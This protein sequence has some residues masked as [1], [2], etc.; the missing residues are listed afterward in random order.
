MEK[1]EFT[2]AQEYRYNRAGP[3]RWIAS[4]VMRYPYLPVTIVLMAVLSNWLRNW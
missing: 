1:R 4:H 3:V 2:I